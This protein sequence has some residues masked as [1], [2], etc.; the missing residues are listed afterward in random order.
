[1]KATLHHLRF[2][3]PECDQTIDAEPEM[4]GTKGKC[5]HCKARINVP[6]LCEECGEM[7]TQAGKKCRSC[8]ALATSAP[9]ISKRALATMLVIGAVLWGL[10]EYEHDRSERE[11]IRLRDEAKRKMNAYDLKHGGRDAP[12]RVQ[13]VND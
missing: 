13:V 1:M 4:A 11:G 10:Y 5:P 8:T 3:C 2:E 9:R 6:R 12:V 7:M